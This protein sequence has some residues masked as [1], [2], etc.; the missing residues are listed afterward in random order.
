MFASPPNRQVANTSS[1][2]SPESM[3]AFARATGSA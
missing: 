3:A 1:P 2:S